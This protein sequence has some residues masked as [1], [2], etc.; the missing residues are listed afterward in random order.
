MRIDI[1]HY[2]GHSL[3]RIGEKLDLVMEMLIQIQRKGE[4]FMQGMDNLIASVQEIKS[5]AD[6]LIALVKGLAD[7]LE[8]F[9][10]DPAK[11]QAIA[12]DLNAKADEIQTAVDTYTP[13]A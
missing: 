3:E 2:H 10:D 11:I 8:E 13:P 1:H 12:D 7:L 6:S 4:V 9:K 5:K